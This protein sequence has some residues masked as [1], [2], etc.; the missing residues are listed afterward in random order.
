MTQ[1]KGA[2]LIANP[3]LEPLLV[4]QFFS[5][6]P[7]VITQLGDPRALLTASWNQCPADLREKYQKNAK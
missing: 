5:S 3:R 6:C 1:W 7:K 2:A 4:A